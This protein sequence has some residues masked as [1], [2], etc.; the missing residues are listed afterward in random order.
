M[1]HFAKLDENNVVLKVIVVTNGAVDNLPFSE[2]EPVGIAFCQSLYGADTVW[3][4]TSYNASFRK[5]YAG[6]GMIYNADIDAFIV[7]QPYPSWTLNAQ[8]GNWDAP[9]PYPSDGAD[10]D[11][12]EEAQ[13]WKRIYIADIFGL[14]RPNVE[15]P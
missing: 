8:S 10:Y 13:T 9:I 15:T 11:W 5:H 3:K 1:A 12:D 6:I 4:Q 7:P 2:S 14:E